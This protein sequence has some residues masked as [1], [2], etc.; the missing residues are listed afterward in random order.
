MFDELTALLDDTTRTLNGSILITSLDFDSNFLLEHFL[1]YALKNSLNCVYISLLTPFSHLKHVQGKMGNVLK[2]SEISSSSP[3][4]FIPLFSSLS[5]QFFHDQTSL[6]IDDLCAIIEKQVIAS[7]E[8]IIIEDLQILRHLLK[9]SDAQILLLQRKLRQIY[10]TAQFITQISLSDDEN[11]DENFSSFLINMLK[12]IH[13]KH[14]F[15]RSLATGATKDINGQVSYQLSLALH[16]YIILLVNLYW[17]ISISF[18][19]KYNHS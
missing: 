4:M 19:D 18:M 15:V 2:T 6:N 14:L 10:P 16:L 12:R 3:L 8:I 13:N 9:Y 1:S 17:S 5:D 7:P 11:D